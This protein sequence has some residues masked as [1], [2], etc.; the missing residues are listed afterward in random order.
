MMPRAATQ[1]SWLSTPYFVWGTTP[2]TAK[3][4]GGLTPSFDG[5]AGTAD[6]PQDYYDNVPSLTVSQIPQ[7]SG[8]YLLGQSNSW[9]FGTF[10]DVNPLVWFHFPTDPLQSGYEG[11]DASWDGPT[12]IKNPKNSVSMGWLSQATYNSLPGATSPVDA[13]GISNGFNI[14]ANVDGSAKATDVRGD[15]LKIVQISDGSFV[16]DKFWPNGR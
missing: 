11:Y 6:Q 4:T 10:W 5:I 15:V 1:A 9:D 7:P 3:I 12:A 8:T 14:H 2:R 16:L 13:D